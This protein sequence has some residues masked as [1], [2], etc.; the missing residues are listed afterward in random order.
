MNFCINS[1]DIARNFIDQWLNFKRYR[2]GHLK[3][4]VRSLLAQVFRLTQIFQ[5]GLKCRNSVRLCWQ[6][7]IMAPLLRVN[8]I[9]NKK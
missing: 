4:T 3:M 7:M 6:Y 1:P 2:L 8:K 5:V 9:K